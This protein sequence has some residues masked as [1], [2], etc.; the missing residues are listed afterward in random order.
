MLSVPCSRDTLLLR[1][2]RTR[3]V[4][5]NYAG[6]TEQPGPTGQ[7]FS[8]PGQRPRTVSRLRMGPETPRVSKEGKLR[9]DR[10]GLGPSIG[11]RDLLRPPGLL[12]PCRGPEPPR[13]PEARAHARVF[14]RKTRPPTAF[15]ADVEACSV[16]TARGAAFVRLRCAPRITKVHSAAACAAPAQSTSAALNGYDG[17]ALFHH[18]AYAAPYTAVG[19][20]TGGSCGRLAHDPAPLGH[21]ASP[22][23]YMVRGVRTGAGG[24]GPLWGSEAPAVSS[25]LPFLRD[26]WR[27][28]THP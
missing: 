9:A 21:V 2:G 1:Q 7:A 19:S 24:P 4:I 28:R 22:D 12:S 13:V 8:S 27:L 26:M 6:R 17:T 10:R 16:A 20:P 25:E 11:V 3:V 23:P 18:A 14:R 15:N 5:R